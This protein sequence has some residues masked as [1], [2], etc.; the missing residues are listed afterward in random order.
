MLH[1][2]GTHNSVILGPDFSAGQVH[3]QVVPPLTWMGATLEEGSPYALVGCTV[4]PAFDFKYF[5]FAD[6][7]Q[8]LERYPDAAKIVQELTFGV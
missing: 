5:E 8:L 3:Q 7:K 4:A 6:R 2:D 1:Q